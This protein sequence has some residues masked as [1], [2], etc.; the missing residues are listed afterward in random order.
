LN[1]VEVSAIPVSPRPMLT[2]AGAMV[3]GLIAGIGAALA[4]TLFR[5]PQL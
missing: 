3:V 5:K 4:T 2:L 1:G